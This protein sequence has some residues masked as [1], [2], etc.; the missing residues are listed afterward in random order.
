MVVFLLGR[1]GSIGHVLAEEDMGFGI[2]IIYFIL[3]QRS[4]SYHQEHT[5][6]HYIPNYVVK[7]DFLP[8]HVVQGS[9]SN[10]TAWVQFL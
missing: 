5:I 2:G 4:M 6:N 7:S 3:P 1:G 10:T 8:N 9:N